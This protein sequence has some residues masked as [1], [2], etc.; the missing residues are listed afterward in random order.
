MGAKLSDS[1]ADWERYEQASS[2]GRTK[3]PKRVSRADFER[4]LRKLHAINQEIADGLMT[5]YP[6]ASARKPELE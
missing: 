3:P 6:D 5:A 1:G 4:A 2:G